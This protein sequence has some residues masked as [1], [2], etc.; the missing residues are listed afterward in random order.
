M[1]C[2][3]PADVDTGIPLVPFSKSSKIAIVGPE[4]P[5][6]VPDIVIVWPFETVPPTPVIAGAASTPDGKHTQNAIATSA[7]NPSELLRTALKIAFIFL[8]FLFQL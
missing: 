8:S 3:L 1:I 7:H 2:A 4:E 5:N 6:P